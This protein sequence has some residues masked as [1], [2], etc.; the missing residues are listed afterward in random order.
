MKI[1]KLT[2][3]LF[4]VSGLS[5]PFC[6]FNQAVAQQD[7]VEKSAPGFYRTQLGQFDVIALS[8]GTVDLPMDKLLHQDSETTKRQLEESFLSVPTE[9]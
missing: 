4:L 1:S 3:Y 2:R 9:T 7:S 5:L 6:A 8:D